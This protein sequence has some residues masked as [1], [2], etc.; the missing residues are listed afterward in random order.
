M[1]N[2]YDTLN[3]MENLV[4]EEELVTVLQVSK[5]NKISSVNNV[6]NKFFFNMVVVRLEISY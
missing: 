6:L 2:V 5:N 3:V 4:C 1:K